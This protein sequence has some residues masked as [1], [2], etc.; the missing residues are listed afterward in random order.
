MKRIIL[1]LIL[2][3]IFLVLSAQDFEI[4]SV[5]HLPNDFSAREEMK[6][7]HSDRQCAL[8]RIA[9]QKITPEQREGFTFKPDLGSEQVE[10]ATRDGEIWLWVSP[11]LKYLRVMHHDWGQYELRMMDYVPTIESLHTYKIVV[12]STPPTLP[13]VDNTSNLFVLMDEN[14][15]ISGDT[16]PYFEKEKE[17]C[18]EMEEKGQKKREN[19]HKFSLWLH[20]T[21]EEMEQ[22]EQDYNYIALP[23]VTYGT[24]FPLSILTSFEW[25]H[26]DKTGVGLCG[27]IGADFTFVDYEYDG[28]QNTITKASFRWDVGFKYYVYNGFF[29]DFGYGSIAKARTSV[30]YPHSWSSGMEDEIRKMVET[31]H[32]LLFHVGYNHKK[33]NDGLLLSV[34]VGCSYDLINRVLAPSLI[35][36]IGGAFSL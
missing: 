28:G 22:P 33:E 32:G 14:K 26:G 13:S 23:T 21:L 1:T 7:D 19:N 24:G 11:G 18:S 25:R 36:K 12:N 29:L 17:D 2:S 3:A 9:T 20:H 35:L 16:M 30:E 34:A 8:L 5:E 15:E 27:D 10:R 4:V 31:G 6:T